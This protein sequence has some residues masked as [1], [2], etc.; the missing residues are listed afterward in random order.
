MNQ[1]SSMF[2]FPA[3]RIQSWII[4]LFVLI[5]L[6]ALWEFWVQIGDVPKWQLPAPSA[7]AKELVV[8]WAL[9][10]RHAFVTL[11]EVV[12]GF[13]VALISGV[14][15]AFGIAYSKALERIVYPIIISSQTIPIIAIAP[16]LLIWLGYGIEPK[17]IVV[18][19]ISFY[20]IAVNT[21]DG[22]KSTDSN[23]AN[24]MRTLGATR[25][26]IFTKLQIP[27][28]LPYMFSGIKVGISISV[29]GAVIGEWVGA[30]AGL[31]YL[32]TY[33]QPLFLTSRVFA[34]IFVLSV[35]GISL[36]LLANL[37]ERLTLPWYYA[38]RRSKLKE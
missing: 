20:P 4:P 1:H 6:V 23:I 7:I 12:I 35:M 31:G 36:F 8:S 22:L 18:A 5:G 38:E 16:L 28:S 34:A 33:S 14:L 15:L 25:W 13:F 29:I 37:A 30:S 10:S 19:L 17:V 32:I 26:Q 24:M 2:K 27:T 9:L 3:I 11:Q 21:I